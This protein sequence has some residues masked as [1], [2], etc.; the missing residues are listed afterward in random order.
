MKHQ[1]L[2]SFLSN[3]T[4]PQTVVNLLSSPKR[5]SFENMHITHED[6]TTFDL[7][8]SHHGL[9]AFQTLLSL[10][11]SKFLSELLQVLRTNT[12]KNDQTGLLINELQSLKAKSPH[13]DADQG[14]LFSL[15]FQTLNT[16]REK[17]IRY[18]SQLMNNT[19]FSH[20]DWIAAY[21]AVHKEIQKD[22]N[23]GHLLKNKLANLHTSINTK[24]HVPIQMPPR[25]SAQSEPRNLT[26]RPG[27]PSHLPFGQS[28]RKIFDGSHS[29]QSIPKTWIHCYESTKP[30]AK[31]KKSPG[32]TNG[33]LIDQ[34]HWQ[35]WYWPLVKSSVLLNK[36]DEQRTE[37][38]YRQLSGF[39]SENKGCVDLSMKDQL[40]RYCLPY[41]VK[42]EKDIIVRE[43][44]VQHRLPMLQALMEEYPHAAHFSQLEGHQ[45]PL[46]IQTL[47]QSDFHSH[48]NDLLHETNMLGYTALQTA[49]YRFDLAWY[50]LLIKCGANPE[51]SPTSVA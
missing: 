16:K 10:N 37:I 7:N 11:P 44:T 49:A 27:K 20:V 8:R 25:K 33:P 22:A 46:K 12:N 15:I 18:A 30:Y 43:N 9:H 32:E 3:D 35:S 19:Y 6:L 24:Y 23:Y 21:T 14:F 51:H 39:F 36:T 40:A 28:P 26:Q 29:S 31:S 48:K 38:V 4:S 2:Q 13:L 34:H 41:S 50:H 5:L 45:I 17:I 1:L 42:N 47:L